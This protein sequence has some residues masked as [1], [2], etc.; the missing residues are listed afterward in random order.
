[1]LLANED[2]T[3]APQAAGPGRNT[4]NSGSGTATSSSAMIAGGTEQE[5][6]KRILG[7]TCEAEMFGNHLVDLL[8][9]R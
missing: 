6:A 3:A 7:G 9:D 1:M 5:R 8:L 2:A 4:V